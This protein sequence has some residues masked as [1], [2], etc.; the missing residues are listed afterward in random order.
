[1]SDR[2][3]SLIER[4]GEL[5]TY[6]ITGVFTDEADVPIA[7]A[8]LSTVRLTLFND[9]DSAI[10]NSVLNQNILNTDRGTVDANGALVCTL[11]PADNVILGSDVEEMHV[12]FFD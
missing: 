12:A 10:I 1:M 2:R 9:A 6:R 7:A 3:V 8:T 11:L 4:A 5:N